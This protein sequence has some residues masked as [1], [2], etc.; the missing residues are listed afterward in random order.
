MPSFEDSFKPR[1]W[2]VVFGKTYKRAI[3]NLKVIFFSL[4]VVYG[5]IYFDE[6]FICSVLLCFVFLTAKK[7]TIKITNINK[8]YVVCSY[9]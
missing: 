4:L 5:H 8:K 9:L 3:F 7:L 2:N 1:M 6:I